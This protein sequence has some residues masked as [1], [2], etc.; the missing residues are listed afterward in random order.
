MKIAT[1]L[2]KQPSGFSLF[3]MLIVIA[4]LGIM[5]SLSL[6]WF[7]GDGSQV[8]QARDQRNAQSFCSLC[9]AAQAAGVVLVTDSSDELEVLR[10][11]VTGVEV[12]RGPLKGRTFRV[13]HV[14]P[15]ELEGAARFLAI[16]QGE[17][18]YS[19]ETRQD[20]ESSVEG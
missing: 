15:D 1:P 16:E 11:L 9:Q 10:Q 12:Q 19:S 3:E 20:G 6:A 7:G 14:E 18:V 17:L 5:T 13:P 8:R 2:N 4:I